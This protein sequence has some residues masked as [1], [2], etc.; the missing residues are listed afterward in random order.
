MIIVDTNILIDYLH[1]PSQNASNVFANNVIATC[2]VVITEMFRGAHSLTERNHIEDI[3]QDFK[4][5]DLEETDWKQLADL[6]IVL[7][8]FGITVPFQDA[9]IAY[10]ALKE[11]C[12]IWTRDKHFSLIKSVIPELELL[13]VA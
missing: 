5:I 3:M 10:L 2:G 7:K 6:F 4:Y 11:S 9:I 1:T 12:T 13:E 8:Q